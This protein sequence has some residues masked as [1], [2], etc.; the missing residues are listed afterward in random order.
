MTQP[1]F[2]LIWRENSNNNTPTYRHNS[3]ASAKAECKRLTSEYGGKFHILA[4]V[5]TAER[6]DVTFKEIDLGQIPL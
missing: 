6:V 1:D 5:A 2:Y 3:Y 4:H